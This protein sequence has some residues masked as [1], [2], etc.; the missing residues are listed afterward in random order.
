MEVTSTDQEN[1]PMVLVAIID[2]RDKLV[3]HY[4]LTGGWSDLVLGNDR[5]VILVNCT[6]QE[7]KP[8]TLLTR[9]YLQDDRV[10]QLTNR[11]HW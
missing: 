5:W 10:Y 9:S 7:D 6:I 1:E 3:A 2:Q 8:V 4:R 11:T